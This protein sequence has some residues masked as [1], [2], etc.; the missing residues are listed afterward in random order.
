MKVAIFDFDKTLFQVDTL[1]FL[2]SRWKLF[3]YSRIKHY[4]VFFSVAWL[5]LKYKTG[6][7]KLSREE[8]KLMAMDRFNR[9]FKGMSES[10]ILEFFNRC[11]EHS[12]E[13]MNISVLAELKKAKSN[14]YHTVLLSG[15][16]THFINYVGDFLEFDTVIGTKMHFNNNIYDIDKKLDTITG[17]KKLDKIQETFDK[18]QVDWKKSISFADSYSDLKILDLVGNP[19]AVNPDKKLKQ[20]AKEKGWKVI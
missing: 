15:S 11:F 13:L 18:N 19:V 17:D 5:Y 3:R 14:G 2:L 12:K 8:M 9:I 6:I 7:T 20:I 10:E 16:Y 1:P 4:K